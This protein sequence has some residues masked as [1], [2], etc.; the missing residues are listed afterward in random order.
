MSDNANVMK[1]AQ[2]G[3]QKLIK[4]EHPNL[5]DVGCICHLGTSL[6]KQV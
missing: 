5:Y 4:N 6:S 2:S 3:V 1:G